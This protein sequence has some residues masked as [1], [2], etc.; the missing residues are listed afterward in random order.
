[1]EFRTKKLNNFFK[2]GLYE[3]FYAKSVTFEF[4]LFYL[5]W[6]F[7]YTFIVQFLRNRNDL[8]CKSY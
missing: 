2:L 3:A 7:F 4:D 5:A 1:M 8:N 6:L